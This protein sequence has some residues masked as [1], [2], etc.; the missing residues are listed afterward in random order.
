MIFGCILLFLLSIVLFF[1]SFAF[2]EEDQKFNIIQGEVPD[3]NY[4]TLFAFTLEDQ[5]G[6]SFQEKIPEGRDYVVS[7]VCNYGAIG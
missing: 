2:Y 5:G 7:V 4:D 1:R 6:Q 3:Q